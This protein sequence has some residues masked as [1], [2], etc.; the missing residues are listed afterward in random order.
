[1]S[2]NLSDIAILNLKRS[3]YSCITTGTSKSKVVHLSQ[4]IDLTEKMGTL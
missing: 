4:N 1:M 3:D 2:I